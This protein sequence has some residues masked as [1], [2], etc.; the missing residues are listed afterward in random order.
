MHSRR[1][2]QIMCC[3]SEKEQVDKGVAKMNKIRILV[4]LVLA[5]PLLTLVVAPAESIEQAQP[6]KVP[7]NAVSSLKAAPVNTGQTP[8]YTNSKQGYRLAS[9]VLD[10]FAGRSESANYR[11]PVN[12]GGQPS[13]VGPSQ[14]TNWGMKAGYV[15]AS[16][17][18][19]G[20]ANADGTV[21]LGDAIYILNYLFRS[22]PNPCPMEA[23]DANYNGAVDL[24]DAIYI[25]NYLFKNG[26]APS[27]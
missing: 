6:E 4:I 21:A 27:C 20:D 22:G 24:G 3:A 1:R 13:A 16:T 11:I 25:L 15:N 23:G 8:I 5:V 14:S 2:D 9:D 12:S 7:P 17:V 10:S 19:H 18:R 26:P